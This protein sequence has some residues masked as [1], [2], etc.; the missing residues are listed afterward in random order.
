MSEI[1]DNK[2]D[3]GT[4]LQVKFKLDTCLEIDFKT[5][6]GSCSKKIM[7]K[8]KKIRIKI[9]KNRLVDRKKPI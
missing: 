7:K 4:V 3:P 6:V 1:E 2:V 9:L 8:I 5:C